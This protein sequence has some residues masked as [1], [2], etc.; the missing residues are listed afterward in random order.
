MNEED[1]KWYAVYTRSRFEQKVYDNF[2]N[3][4]MEAFLPKMQVMSKRKDRRKKILVP[5]FPGYVFLKY[6]LDP[7]RY[8]DI[9]KTTGVV[10]ML[11]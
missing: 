7:E 6:D 4:S 9:I 5:I 1:L 2:C 11:G 3:K 8:Y 10:R